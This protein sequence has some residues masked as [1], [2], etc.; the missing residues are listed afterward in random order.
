MSGRMLRPLLPHFIE[1]H[2]PTPQNQSEDF[3]TYFQEYMA[4]GEE[5]QETM[6]LHDYCN[7]NYRNRPREGP[8]GALGQQ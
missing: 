6:S 5:F 4:L 3:S 1:E 2:Q 8:R 7:I